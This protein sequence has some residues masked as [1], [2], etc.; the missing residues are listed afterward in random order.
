MLRAWPVCRALARA[1]SA[2]LSSCLAPRGS[3]H[4]PPM[5]L[6][7]TPQGGEAAGCRLGWGPCRRVGGTLGIGSE[8][9]DG[10]GGEG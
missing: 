1:S 5:F 9:G 4:T 10:G 6:G 3:W 8:E 7:L 2:G